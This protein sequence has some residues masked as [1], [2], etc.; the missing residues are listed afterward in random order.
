MLIFL[1]KNYLGQSDKIDERIFETKKVSEKYTKEINEQLDTLMKEWNEAKRDKSKATTLAETPRS[2]GDVP[3][4]E[5]GD[6]R[7]PRGSGRS[8]GSS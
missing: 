5:D 4:G 2:Y 7:L 6:A 1:G 8:D 3:Q